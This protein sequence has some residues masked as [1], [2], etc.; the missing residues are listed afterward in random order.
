MFGVLLVAALEWAK[1][2]DADLVAIVD[3]TFD[4]FEAGLKL[5]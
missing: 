5:M 4:Q 3:A 1:S 2:P